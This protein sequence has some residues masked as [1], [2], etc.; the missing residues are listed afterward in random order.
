MPTPVT[1]PDLL[2]Q[3][4]GGGDGPRPV[5][6]PDL[7]KQL[8]APKEDL[9]SGMALSG[10]P[11][12]GAYVPQAE[13]AIR[14]AAQ[15]LTG[16]GKPGSSFSDRY[17]ANLPERQAAYKQ[18]EA[19]SPIGSTVAKG[20]GGT[21]AL[22][23]LGATALG[24]RAL[25]LTGSLPARL[26]MGAAS[27]AGISAADTAVRGGD[28]EEIK[29]AALLGGGLGA[30]APA[31]SGAIEK[32]IS[33][34]VTRAGRAP[35]VAAARAEG[36]EPTAGQITGSRPLQWAEQHL[37]EL[38]GV[39]PAERVAEKFT[40]AALQRAGVNEARLTPDV[41][42]KAFTNIGKEF[43]GLGARTTLVP[44]KQ[45]GPEFRHA[46]AEYD[47]LVA[48]PQRS[49][50]IRAY[51]EEVGNALAANRGQLP[52]D[53]YQS[54]RSRMEADARGIMRSDPIAAK[55]L[56]DMREVLDA[57]MTRS[58]QRTNSPDLGAWQEARQQYRNLLVLEKVAGNPNTQNGLV[59]PAALFQANKQIM[60]LRN[61]T[62]GRGDMTPLAQAGSDLLRQLPSS[63]T[64]Q[65]SYF[66]NTIPNAI[67]GAAYGTYQGDPLTAIGGAGLGVGG[68]QLA[69]RALMNALG[70]TLSGQ[71]GHDPGAG[72][73]AA[74]WR[75]RRPAGHD[76]WG[77]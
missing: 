50:A 35:A 77:E 13:A 39:S 14:A 21:L 68:P 51:E 66:Q 34:I 12:L 48:P 5:T 30:A 60:G 10:I 70:A 1:D 46:I 56:R 6:D 76:A 43:D 9:S 32:A 65:R 33:P 26:G 74:R 25:G 58:L 8:D 11:L 38:A 22:A 20:I 69:G 62:R 61:A 24:A 57:G 31:I 37:G 59:T 45:L 67:A 54:L 36:I 71:P 41:V 4:E 49:P 64:A 2:K 73:G 27:G 17:T 75:G 19:D 40:G 16:V 53:V 7:L 28:T 42:D 47:R 15:P 3:L 72:A 44:D 29:N 63:G 55:G 18:A 52:G 23:P